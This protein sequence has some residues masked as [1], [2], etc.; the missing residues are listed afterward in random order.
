MNDTN[1]N[2]SYG[3]EYCIGHCNEWLCFE[4]CTKTMSYFSGYNRIFFINKW[5]FPSLICERNETIVFRSITKIYERMSPIKNLVRIIPVFLDSQ[6]LSVRWF[7]D[8]EYWW[9]PWQSYQVQYLS[10]GFIESHSQ[11]FVLGQQYVEHSQ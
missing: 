5:K 4:Y 1:N 11:K 6:E 2:K 8:F 9:F 10:G 7:L 3:C